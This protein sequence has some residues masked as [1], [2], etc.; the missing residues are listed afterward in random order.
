MAGSAGAAIIPLL[1]ALPGDLI[2]PKRT[3]S[4]FYDT[5][6]EPL[7][8]QYGVDTVVLTGQHSNMCVRHTA[9]DAFFRGDRITAECLADSPGP[10][11]RLS[12]AAP[13]H[14]SNRSPLQPRSTTNSR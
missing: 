12:S 13:Y 7:L 2:L 8:R 11:R 14:A 10:R 4:C 1:G 5:G 6:L 3:Y 9:A